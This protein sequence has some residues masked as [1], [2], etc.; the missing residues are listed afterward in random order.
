LRRTYKNNPS[1]ID[2]SIEKWLFDVT[3]R[4]SAHLTGHLL[5]LTSHLA[6]L[7]DEPG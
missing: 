4:V 2:G 5:L 3:I 1:V 7:S 6:G